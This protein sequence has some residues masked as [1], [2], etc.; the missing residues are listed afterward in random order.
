MVYSSQ[1]WLRRRMSYTVARM[2]S[3]YAGSS[4]PLSPRR[5]R[6]MNRCFSL[7]SG[8]HEMLGDCRGATTCSHVPREG[9]Q[10][11]V[12]G[13]EG[14]KVNDVVLWGGEDDGAGVLPRKSCTV[15]GIPPG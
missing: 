6:S 12:A 9:V 3:R 5:M 7:G 4:F 15:G 14:A 2:W 8:R 13:G 11:A 10:D 1:S